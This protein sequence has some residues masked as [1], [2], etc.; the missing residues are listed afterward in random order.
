MEIKVLEVRD[1]ATCIPV[2]AIKMVAANPVEAKFLRRYG[3]PTDG[4]AVVWM[5]MSDQSASVDP[6]AWRDRTRAASHNFIYDH[7][8]ELENG[9]VVDVRVILKETD[10]SAEPEIWNG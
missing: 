7:F 3:Y 6:Y 8:D 1:E 10:N 9:D 4:S 5:H 2:L